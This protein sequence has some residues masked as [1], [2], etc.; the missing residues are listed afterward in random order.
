MELRKLEQNENGKTRP[1]W[2]H[3]FNEDTKAFLDY[4]YFFK[5]RDN[6]IY[7]VEEDGKICSML[8]LNP[9]LLQ[10]EESRFTGNYI[11]G[12]ATEPEYRKRGY[13]GAL[14]RRSIQEMYDRGELFTFLMP[15]AEA[16]YTPYDFRFVYDQRQCEL[17][18]NPENTEDADISKHS[19]DRAGI[20]MTDA[21]MGDAGELAHFF[22]EHF[23]EKW[24]VYA[25]RDEAY[26]QS[27]LFERQSE[28]GGIKMI[29]DGERLVGTFTYSDEGGLEILEPLMLEGYDE[30]FR[31][32][33]CKMNPVPEVPVRVYAYGAWEN[34]K[35]GD[36]EKPMIMAR[37]LRPEKLLAEMKVKK[38]ESLDCTFAVLDFLL[39]QNSRI[40]RVQGDGREDGR[41]RVRE[42]ENSEGVL[43]IGALT[44]FLFGYKTI[45][46]TAQEGDVILTGHLAAELKKI[47]PLQ[48]IFFNELV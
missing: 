31:Q 8:Q 13:M 38:G 39:P 30:A 17:P 29:R 22:R 48:N 11:I 44:S 40:W 6:E 32:C 41:I 3:V 24:Q 26:Y 42:T 1:L 16:I 36:K 25:V 43:P 23:A 33:I 45:E 27:L 18:V 12:V 5:A 10:V 19:D 2:E 46:E 7:V 21:S 9:Y 14:L 4:Y 37:I 28:N 47:E 15:A 34:T 35:P 20:A